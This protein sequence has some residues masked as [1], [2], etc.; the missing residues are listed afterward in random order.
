MLD[1]RTLR[2]LQQ[3]VADYSD[4]LNEL[5]TGENDLAFTEVEPERCPLLFSAACCADKGA[6]FSHRPVRND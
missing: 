3:I 5:L 2:F 1:R 6:R 4:R